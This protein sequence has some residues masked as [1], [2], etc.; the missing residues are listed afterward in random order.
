VSASGPHG[1]FDP[2]AVD[3]ASL[4]EEEF[5][6][7]YDPG[8]YHRPSVT[9]DVVA[10]TIHHGR[11][12]VLLVQRAGHPFRGCW[13]L[14][15]GYRNPA[16][17]LDAAARRELAE[18]TGIELTDAHIEQL[19]TFG[20]PGRDPRGDVVSVA[21]VAFVPDL[22][23]PTAGSD[24]AAARFWPVEDLGD[25]DGPPLAFDH[26]DIVAAGVERARAKLEYTNLATFFVSEPFTVADLRRVYSAVW[27]VELHAN[28][29]RRKVTSTPG[30]L[31]PTGESVNLGRGK[32]ALLFSRG[33]ATVLSVPILRPDA[34]AEG[35]SS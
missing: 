5:L 32:P 6:A 14:P 22:P 9:V 7:A 23:L 27:G 11:L 1:G 31:V 26:A 18:E 13:A 29:F 3:P 12:C 4:T 25:V 35:V 30:F 2:D 33:P 8:R 16:E 21:Y 17:P 15:G 34:D 20:D 28:N 10:L 19:A 24:A